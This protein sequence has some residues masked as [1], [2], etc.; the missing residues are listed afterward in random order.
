MCLA[1]KI[2]KKTVG[3]R[4]KRKVNNIRVVLCNKGVKKQLICEK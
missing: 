1:G 4:E 2:E 3:R